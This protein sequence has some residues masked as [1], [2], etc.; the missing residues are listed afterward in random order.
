MRGGRG[1][2][3]ERA[4][5]DCV[6]SEGAGVCCVWGGGGPGCTPCPRGPCPCGPC[7]LGVDVCP[8]SARSTAALQH[9]AVGAGPGWGRRT[10]GR[11]AVGEEACPVHAR[12]MP[13]GV[14]AGQRGVPAW[15][16]GVWGRA[17]AWPHGLPTFGVGRAWGCSAWGRGSRVRRGWGCSA[18]VRADGDQEIWAGEDGGGARSWSC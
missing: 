12:C 3:G 16:C 11:G 17:Q 14:V 13:G 1:P 8:Q 2:G 15:L 7:R 18:A 4:V 5:P 6:A 9:A 10:H